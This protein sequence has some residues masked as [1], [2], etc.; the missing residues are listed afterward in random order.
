MAPAV[1]RIRTLECWFLPINARA[2]RIKY[3]AKDIVDAGFLELVRLGIRKPCT[4][5][6]EESLKVSMQCLRSTRPVD[7][8]GSAITTTDMA[9]GMTEVPYDGW[10]VGRP[11][12]LLTLERAT[13]EF[14]AGRD[15]DPYLKAVSNFTTGIGMIPEQIWDA[16]DLPR[17]HM[18]FGKA[19]G[20]ADPLLWAHAEYVKLLRSI[21]DGRIFDLIEPV[22]ERYRNE[23]ARPSIEVWK[24]N[25][26]VKCV[27]V[28]GL[29]RIQASS[30]FSLHWS[31]DEWVDPARHRIYADFHR[32]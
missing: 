29:L 16:P 18:C 19:T 13:Y 14:A 1:T 8:A 6:M 17:A 2:I 5:L 10:G 31:N 25:R 4:P 30:P 28:G 22:A 32:S 20:A 3:P 9:S 27:P 21:A 12:P 15:V 11:W 7:R 26:Q 24:I 23:E